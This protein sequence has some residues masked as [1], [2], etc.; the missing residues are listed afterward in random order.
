MRRYLLNETSSFLNWAH[1]AL[2]ARKG[3]QTHFGCRTRCQYSS[4]IPKSC[5]LQCWEVLAACRSGRNFARPLALAR[6]LRYSTVV[7][8]AN[9]QQH[10][11]CMKI[12][13]LLSVEALCERVLFKQERPH[14][15]ILSQAQE[16]QGHSCDQHVCDY[17]ACCDHFTPACL[18]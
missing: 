1:C 18:R 9:I 5:F 12:L 17:H 16:S 4:K 3:Y 6:K 2:C 10:L 7:Q 13:I 11:R 8:A 14:A 15:E